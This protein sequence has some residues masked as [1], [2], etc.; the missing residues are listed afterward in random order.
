MTAE[1]ETLVSILN[2]LSKSLVINTSIYWMTM[3]TSETL[4]CNAEKSTH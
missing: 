2:L 4:L 1:T 3:V